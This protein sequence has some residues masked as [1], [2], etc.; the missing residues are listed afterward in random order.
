VHVHSQQLEPADRVLLYTDNVT[1]IRS[2]AGEFS[3]SRLAG[4]AGRQPGRRLPT[5]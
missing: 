4:P 2:A 5:R 3:A 1:D